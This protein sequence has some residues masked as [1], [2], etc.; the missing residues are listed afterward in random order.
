MTVLIHDLF[1]LL[2][3]DPMPPDMLDVTLVPLG[4]ET[5]EPHR[6]NVS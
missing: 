3:L 6:P 1:D 2:R 4:L 5:P